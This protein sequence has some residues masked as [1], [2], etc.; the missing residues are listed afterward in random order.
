VYDIERNP[1]CAWAPAPPPPQ[2]DLDIRSSVGECAQLF[3]KKAVVDDSIPRTFKFNL[4]QQGVE[5]GE[6]CGNL[7]AQLRATGYAPIQDP[8]DPKT[9]RIVP[10]ASAAHQ[11][12]KP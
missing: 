5:M 9:V 10:I 7:D 2:T 8:S 1:N 11:I 4:P 6:W 12:R 3:G